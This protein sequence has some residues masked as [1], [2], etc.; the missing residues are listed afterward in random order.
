MKSTSH[1]LAFEQFI[2]H[3]KTLTSES[4]CLYDS[5]TPSA[6]FEA[7]ARGDVAPGG[8]FETLMS[9]YSDTQMAADLLKCSV[10]KLPPKSALVRVWQSVEVS[11]HDFPAIFPGA[12]VFAD[13]LDAQ[14]HNKQST[15]ERYKLLTTRVFANELLTLGNPGHFIYIPRSVRASYSRYVQD[16]QAELPWS[17]ELQDH[18][19]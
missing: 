4:D 11:E 2:R 3:L 7:R 9:W 1:P 12:A 16:C 13:A 15:P 5:W 6:A 19:D 17:S 18:R 14:W 10:C 8:E